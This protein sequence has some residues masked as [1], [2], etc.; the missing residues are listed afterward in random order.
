MNPAA[1]DTT[2][3]RRAALALH[4]L[5][6]ADRS[7]I[8][9]RLRA[10]EREALEPLLA[11]LS[12]L[13]IPPEPQLVRRLLSAQANTGAAQDSHVSDARADEAVDAAVLC[14]VVEAEPS[15]LRPYLLATLGGA[16]LDALRAG[17]ITDHVSLEPLPDALRAALT[18]ALSDR[19]RQAMEA[20]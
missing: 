17:G 16:Q 14:A 5:S 2:N 3:Q 6:A 13:R 15:A 8:W 9:G 20:A 12:E 11:E 1:T 19:M 10:S 18:R 7:W 4:A